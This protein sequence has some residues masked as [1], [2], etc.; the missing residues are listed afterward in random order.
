[1]RPIVRE[2]LENTLEHEPAKALTGPIARGEIEVVNKHLEALENWD[3]PVSN[4]YRQLGAFAIEIS[5]KKGVASEENLKVI[6]RLLS[7]KI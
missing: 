6:E 5:R 7:E 2:T 3:S 1:M 4:L